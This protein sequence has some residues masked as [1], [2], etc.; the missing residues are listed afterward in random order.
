MSSFTIVPQVNQ[1]KEFMEIAS[2]FGQPLEL[3]R[4]AISNA[5]DA[6]ARQIRLIFTTE[7]VKGVYVL[8]IL[9]EDSGSGMDRNGLQAFFDL[10][11]SL[12]HSQKNGRQPQRLAVEKCVQLSELASFVGH[13]FISALYRDE[14]LT[15]P[16]PISFRNRISPSWRDVLSRALQH[17]IVLKLDAV[18]FDSE[19]RFIWKLRQFWQRSLK[20]IALAKV[21]ACAFVVFVK[22]VLQTATLRWKR[23]AELQE[24]RF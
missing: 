18:P 1:A 21:I 3:L 11:N 7:L 9:I 14:V 16:N 8:K 17:L 2:D 19:N 15:E 20:N 23:M 4:E 24:F 13:D 22:E 10:G 6:G 12:R 5:F